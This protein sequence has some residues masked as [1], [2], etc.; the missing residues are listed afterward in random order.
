MNA[1]QSFDSALNIIASDFSASRQPS[2]LLLITYK[3]FH[4]FVFN[5][6]KCE[7]EQKDANWMKVRKPLRFEMSAAL[8]DKLAQIQ[9]R[10][11][12]ADGTYTGGS[13]SSNENLQEPLKHPNTF[14]FTC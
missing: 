8:V 11:I 1:I 5:E 6:L 10:R 9:I 12:Q 3:V 7:I 2:E 4:D 13:F 14:F